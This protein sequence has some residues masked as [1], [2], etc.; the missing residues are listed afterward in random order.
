MSAPCKYQWS[1][2]YTE[3]LHCGTTGRKHFCIG[4]CRKCYDKKRNK[5]PKRK[6]QVKKNSKRQYLRIKDTEKFRE[7]R[8]KYMKEFRK[9]ISGKLAHKRKLRQL[10][11]KRYIEN[12]SEKKGKDLKR[13]KNGLKFRCEGCYKNCLIT[14]NISPD[15]LFSIKNINIFREEQIKYCKKKAN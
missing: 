12:I 4:L 7:S 14:S 13:N 11:Y 2:K 8:N 9:T 10:K 15:S 1:W 6:E 5:D 3:C